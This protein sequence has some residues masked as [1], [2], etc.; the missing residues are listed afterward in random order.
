LKGGIEAKG[1]SLGY[2]GV[3]ALIM[4]LPLWDHEGLDRLVA[5]CIAIIAFVY[6]VFAT[7]FRY[8]KCSFGVSDKVSLYGGPPLST[9]YFASLEFCTIHDH[10][11]PKLK[12]MLCMRR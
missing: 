11:P 6:I 4:C 5:M 7:E 2:G 3:E 1:P 10:K 8:T 9:V 12:Q